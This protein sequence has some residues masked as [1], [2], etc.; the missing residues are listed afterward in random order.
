[1]SKDFKER[2]SGFMENCK[3]IFGNEKHSKILIGYEMI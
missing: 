1:M 2:W 3:L